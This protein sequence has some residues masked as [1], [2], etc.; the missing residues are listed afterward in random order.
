MCHPRSDKFIAPRALDAG[1]PKRLRR[2]LVIALALMLSYASPA[3]GDDVAAYLEQHGL[4]Q[5]L[6]VHLEGQVERATGEQREA[7]LRR[8]A[9]LYAQMLEREGDPDRRMSLEQR[10]RRLLDQAPARSGDELRLALLRASYRTAEKIAENHRLR[11]ARDDEVESARRTFAAITPEL[12][13]LAAQM[14]ENVVTLD[15]RVGRSSGVDSVALSESLDRARAQ[16]AQCVFLNAWSL[17]Y[18]DWLA[19]ERSSSQNAR[20]A[21]TLFAEL[22]EA[23]NATPNPE[24]VSVDLRASEAVARSILGM[25]LCKSLTSSPATAIAWVL[26]LTH[27]QAFEPLRE[28]AGV[29]EMVIQLEHRSYR[30]ALDTLDE[31]RATMPA[32]PLPWLRLCAVH[33]LEDPRRDRFAEELVK[34]AVTELAARGELQQVLDLATRYGVQ[35]LGDSGFALKYVQGVIRYQEARKQHDSEEPS[36]DSNLRTLY[37]EAADALRLATME[38]DASRYPLA[39]AACRR[40]VAWCAYF[41]ANFIEAQRA[42]ESAATALSGADAAD[43]LWMAIVSLDRLPE[44]RRT[45]ETQMTLDGLVDRYIAQYP[46]DPNTARLRLKR[47]AR[48]A[49]PTPDAVAELLSIPPGNDAYPAAQSRAADM[50][51]QLFRA[52]RGNDRLAWGGQFLNV[53]VALIAQPPS[54]A[55]TSMENAVSVD[56]AVERFVVRCRQVL[57]VALAEGIERAGAARAAFESL[58]ALTGMQPGVMM[59]HRDEIDCRRAQERLIAEDITTAMRIADELWERDSTSIWARLAVRSIFKQAHARWKATE[60]PEGEL[61]AAQ[62][63]VVRYGGRVLHEFRDDPNALDRQ[64]AIGYYAA[65]AEATMGLWE[66]T[67]ETDRAKA[68]LFLFEALLARRP[69]N[70]AFLRSAAI[71]SEACDL[72]HKA[73][74]HWRKIVA[75]T[76]VGSLNWFEGKFNQIQLLARLDPPRAREVMNQHKRLHP[77]YGPEPW[78]ARL[79]G[80]DELIPESPAPASGSPAS[81]PHETEGGR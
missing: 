19:I 25:A 37:R 16:L 56:P 45:A 27:P 75:G 40:L 77:Q 28:Q 54:S 30:D 12:Q 18:Q 38:S 62:E 32:I 73:L 39:V 63:R 1:E 68:A 7:I 14:R 66:R 59:S 31:A 21:E 3:R 74:D 55:I 69:T 50:L 5:L 64:G 20:Q 79:K 57:E 26:L 78:G 34:Y 36:L 15:R 49:E 80:L 61:H 29:W 47:S 33:A 9:D 23:G 11:L 72:P 71:L 70:A 76:N 53:A 52:A 43:A 2:T 65:V 51:Y 6:A 58:E 42:F 13:T 46:S 81:G 60:V 22:M 44:A 48:D 17:Y 10:S 4:I 67:R 8:L 35:S 24:E 41:Q